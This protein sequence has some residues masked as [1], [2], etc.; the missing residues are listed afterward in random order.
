[1][2]GIE[3][4][5]EHA[6]DALTTPGTGAGSGVPKPFKELRAFQKVMLE[7]GK[8]KEIL[9]RIDP[10]DLAYF[11]KRSGSWVTERGT[12]TLYAGFSSRDIRQ[13]TEFRIE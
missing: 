13:V 2:K 6:I 12:Y 9:M 4:A 10:G 8:E 11:D 3:T 7:P 5:G 1:M